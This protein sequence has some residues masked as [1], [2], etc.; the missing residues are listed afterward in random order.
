MQ[1]NKSRI[2]CTFLV[3]GNNKALL[4]VVWKRKH[5]FL[6]GVWNQVKIHEMHPRNYPPHARI[7]AKVL[8][9]DPSSPPH[10]LPQLHISIATFPSRLSYILANDNPPLPSTR[11]QCL[12]QNL[13]EKHHFQNG[14]WTKWE[15]VQFADE[16]EAKQDM[17]KDDWE[18]W[19]EAD[20][21]WEGLDLQ[22]N[23]PLLFE[24]DD[25]WLGLILGGAL[26]D[27]CSSFW[28]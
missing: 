21:Q 16:L 5:R 2:Q 26:C 27:N 17:E 14:G 3:W 23:G 19:K 12:R 15:A 13:R 22:I 1:R 28:Y 18:Y 11:T 4:Q 25:Q 10:P 7:H 9:R 6:I 20:K 8:W 24:W